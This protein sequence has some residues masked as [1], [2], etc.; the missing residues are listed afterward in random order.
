MRPLMLFVLLLPTACGTQMLTDKDDV[1]A[2]GDG[3]FGDEDCDDSDP[4][5]NPDGTELCNDVDDDCDGEVDNTAADGTPWYLDNDGDGAGGLESIEACSQPDGYT[6]ESGDCND[7]DAAIFPSADEICDG[8]DNNCDGV[9]DYDAIDAQTWYLD[10]DGDGYGDPNNAV[11][12]CTPA[13]GYIEKGKDCDDSN[14]QVHPG[15][16]EACDGSDANCDGLIDND[17]DGDGYADMACGGLDCDDTDINNYNQCTPGLDPTYPGLSCLD[18]ITIDAT[19]TD[20]AYWL[21]PN[22]GDPSDSFEAY[23]DMTTDGGGWTVTYLVDAEY[24]DGVYANNR[25]TS[26]APPTDINSQRDIWNAELVM[27]FDE[28]MFGCTTQSDSSTHWW[29]YNSISPHTWFTDTNGGYNYQ[30]IDSDS[31]STS[32]STCI[33]TYND[34]GSYGFMV[35]ESDTCGSCNTMLYGMY[36]YPA[37][38]TGC[39]STSTSYGSHA[40]PYDGRSIDYPICNGQQT[41]NGLFWMGVR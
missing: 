16:K 31:W 6:A 10:S 21:D 39:N 3:F 26:S 1:D 24:F 7:S 38:R 18:I 19:V 11:V 2:D 5:V 14:D 25:T 27:S 22:G 41:S 36:H 23:C 12:T 28:V 29:V 15:A 32:Q 8:V 20:G 40:S 35:L 13:F 17:A 4:A 37:S 33:S 9:T 34:P 30:Y